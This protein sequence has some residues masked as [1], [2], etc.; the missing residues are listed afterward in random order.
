MLMSTIPDTLSSFPA[1]YNGIMG[2]SGQVTEEKK[3]QASSADGSP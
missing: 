1:C 2:S 3:A